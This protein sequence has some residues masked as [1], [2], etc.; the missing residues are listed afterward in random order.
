MK[1]SNKVISASV[2]GYSLDD[3]IKVLLIKLSEDNDR[4]GSTGYIKTDADE[5]YEIYTR[6]GDGGVGAIEIINPKEFIDS[7]SA[8]KYTVYGQSIK[9]LAIQ[10]MEDFDYDLDAD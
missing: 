9:E 7:E 5:L 8:D 2:Y 4:Y 10:A 3:D 6:E 1:N